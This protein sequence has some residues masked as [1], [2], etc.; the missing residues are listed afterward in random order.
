MA[1]AP[2]NSM[3]VV[4]AMGL[5]KM[6]RRTTV[7]GTLQF[8]TQSPERSADSVDDQSGHR[9]TPTC[10]RAFPHLAALPR[11]HGRGRGEGRER[12]PQLELAAV[13]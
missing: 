9:D 3:N 5:Y 13:P 1:L 12:A 11:Q 4:S 2:S 7:N 8:T 6:A 10:L